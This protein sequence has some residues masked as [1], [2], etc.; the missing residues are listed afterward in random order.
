MTDLNT[1]LPISNNAIPTK[2]PS[3]KLLKKVFMSL[4]PFLAKTR[5][6][7]NKACLSVSLNRSA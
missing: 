2:N 1:L 7:P 5:N 3:I 4:D 6:T